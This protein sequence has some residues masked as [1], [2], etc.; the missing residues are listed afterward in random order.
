M[1]VK[2]EKSSDNS[3]IIEIDFTHKVTAD[4][5]VY[6]EDMT[7]EQLLQFISDMKNKLAALDALE[8]SDDNSEE[9]DDWADEHEEIEDI[10][11][12]AL[13]RLDE[14]G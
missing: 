3:K 10:I 7:P 2:N 13:D 12:E 11:D 14:I 5:D 4:D 6:I 9:Y 1:S 8:P